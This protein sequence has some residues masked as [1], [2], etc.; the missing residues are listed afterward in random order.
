[1]TIRAVKDTPC[2]VLDHETEWDWRPHYATEQRANESLWDQRKEAREEELGPGDTMAEIR[3][4]LL[5]SVARR[6]P[7]PCLELICDGCDQA[8][9]MDGELVDVGSGSHFEDVDEI[10]ISDEGWTMSGAEHF[11]STCSAARPLLED[12][13]RATGPYDDPLIGLDEVGQVKR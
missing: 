7:R 8:L 1:M 9:G 2:W 3:P 11:C 13:V 12:D 10:T 5:T 6:E 4:D